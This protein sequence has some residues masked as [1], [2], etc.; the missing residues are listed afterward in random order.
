MAIPLAGVWLLTATTA[1][2]ADWRGGPPAVGA[3]TGRLTMPAVSKG[4]GRTET[5]STVVKGDSKKR[6][7]KVKSSST[8]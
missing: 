6:T 2:H 1:A 4:K 5:H 7:V 8:F 3:G